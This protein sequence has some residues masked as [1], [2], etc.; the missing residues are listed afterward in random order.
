PEE[1]RVLQEKYDEV[2]AQVEDE[3]W[4]ARKEDALQ[5]IQS[6][7][8]WNSPERFSVLGAIEYMDRLEAG[9]DTAG[10][11]LARLRGDRRRLP[12]DLVGRVAQ[13]LY[14]LDSACR[15]LSEGE[16]R[17]AFLL[18]SA[19]TEPGTDRPTSDR[20]ARQLARMY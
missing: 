10:S 3:A 7:D 8:F 19:G 6:A 14:L 12:P 2:A 9:L 1:L 18:V 16:P 11:L 17:D 4:A 15:G 13:Q 5:E 20:F